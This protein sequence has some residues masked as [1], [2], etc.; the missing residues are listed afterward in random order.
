MTGD[1]ALATGAASPTDAA[2]PPGTAAP[3]DTATADPGAP[4]PAG[5]THVP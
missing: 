3:T 5:V 4:E 2:Q 1:A